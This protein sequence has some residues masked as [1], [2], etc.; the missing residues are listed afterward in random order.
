M[1]LPRIWIFSGGYSHNVFVH[2]LNTSKEVRTYDECHTN[3]INSAKFANSVP[4]LFT[5][6]SFDHSLKLFDVRDRSAV[7]KLLNMEMVSNSFFC[8]IQFTHAKP[9]T[10]VWWSRGLLMIGKLMQVVSIYPNVAITDICYCLAPTTRWRS[11]MQSTARSTWRIRWS[12]S[13]ASTT[14]L[15]LTTLIV[16]NTSL[17]DRANNRR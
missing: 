17:L 10:N 12:Q 3:Y 15:G 5:T 6:S 13:T 1:P 14:T 9:K 16:V 11:S 4:Y 7:S 2:D 8:R